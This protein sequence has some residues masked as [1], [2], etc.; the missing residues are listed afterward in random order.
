MRMAR[1]LLVL[2]LVTRGGAMWA[3]S[4]PPQR[5]TPGV[6]FLPGDPQK[7]YSNNVVIEMKDL[8]HRCRR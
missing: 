8:S 4:S 1:V 6:W 7:G 5:I 2:F 3:Q